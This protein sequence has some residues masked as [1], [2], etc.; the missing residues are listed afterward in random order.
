MKLLPLLSE[1]TSKYSNQV[2]TVYRSPELVVL[3]PKNSKIAA[4]YSHGTNWCSQTSQG[5]CA[6]RTEEVLFR[7]LFKD[8][9]KLR[10]N[11]R[12][13]GAVGHWGGPPIKN[14]H[15][16]VTTFSR[17]IRNIKTDG[18][19]TK[20]VNKIK[21]IPDDAAQAVIEY[22]KKNG[23][24]TTEE[25]KN[26]VSQLKDLARKYPALWLDSIQRYDEQTQSM[27][28]QIYVV[29]DFNNTVG[30]FKVTQSGEIFNAKSTKQ[31]AIPLEKFNYWLGQKEQLSRQNTSKKTLEIFNDT[32]KAFGCSSIPTEHGYQIWHGMVML[33]T[34]EIQHDEFILKSKKGNKSM[35]DYELRSFLDQSLSNRRTA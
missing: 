1:V 15:Y 19:P 14:F 2:D 8:G 17:D 25:Q 4:K 33:G 5:F 31:K 18:F 10:L 32:L 16:P 7:F 30:L 34:V 27:V 23:L 20:L 13:G 21:S 9:T 35:D 28:Y 3:A 12:N 26:T 6:H 11:V 29:D 22:T 24:S